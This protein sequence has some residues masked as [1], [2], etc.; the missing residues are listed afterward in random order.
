[1][2]DISGWFPLIDRAE[3]DLTDRIHSRRTGQTSVSFSLLLSS[4]PRIPV[5]VILK[6]FSSQGN[7]A[8]LRL[9]FSPVK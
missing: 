8:H 5:A 2:G 3:Q 1:V 9:R 7:S 4:E 6:L